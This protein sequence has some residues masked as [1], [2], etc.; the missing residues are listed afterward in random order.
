MLEVL[1]NYIKTSWK[2]R[3]LKGTKA[4]LGKLRTDKEKKKRDKE[5]ERVKR[6]EA[7]IQITSQLSHS[8]KRKYLEV[9]EVDDDKQNEP[10]GPVKRFRI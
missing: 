5:A 2:R 10:F 3:P 4:S 8:K 9:F 6:D 7:K 1:E